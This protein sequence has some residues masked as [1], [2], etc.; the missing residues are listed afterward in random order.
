MPPMLTSIDEWTHW[1]AECTWKL[2]C[3]TV[4][5]RK[6]L[7]MGTSPGLLGLYPRALV[8]SGE[9]RPVATGL[10]AGRPRAM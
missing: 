2:L 10:A 8:F 3:R 9:M 6:G 1:L 4:P 7:P 5:R